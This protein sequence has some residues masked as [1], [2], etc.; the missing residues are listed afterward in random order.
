VL[1][2]RKI[3]GFMPNNPK[4]EEDYIQE[5]FY[6]EMCGRTTKEETELDEKLNKFLCEGCRKEQERKNK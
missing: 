2:D 6:C 1:I 4:K 3:G 5:D